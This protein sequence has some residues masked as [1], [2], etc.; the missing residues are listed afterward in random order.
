MM[1]PGRS[2]REVIIK[3]EKHKRCLILSTRIFSVFLTRNV[4]PTTNAAFS[5]GKSCVNYWLEQSEEE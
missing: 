1:A 2:A 3:L 5:F 4:I